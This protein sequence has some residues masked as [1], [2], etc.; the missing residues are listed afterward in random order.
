[1]TLQILVHG[2]NI[3][4]CIVFVYGLHWGVAGAGFGTLLGEFVSTATG[5][6]PVRAALWRDAEAARH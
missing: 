2:V 3:I 6:R 4:S 1:M 5:P